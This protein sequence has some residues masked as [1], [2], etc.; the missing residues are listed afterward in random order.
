MLT[1]VSIVTADLRRRYSDSLARG[2]LG[3]QSLVRVVA[4]N[5]HPSLKRNGQ[6]SQP[7]LPTYR[8]L[9]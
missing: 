4:Q 7:N 3:Y 5:H 8:P 6:E 9:D 2:K 1:E